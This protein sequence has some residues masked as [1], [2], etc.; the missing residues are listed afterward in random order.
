MRNKYRSK[1]ITRDGLTFD[2]LKEYR[3]F[4]ELL[5]LEKSGAITDLKRQVAFELVPA[6]FEYIKTDEVYKRGER[7]GLPKFKRVCVE[8]SVVYNADFTYTEK[9]QIV[10]EDTKGFRTKDY[11]IKRKLML[12]FHDI[13][14][15]EI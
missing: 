13:K 8:Q 5:L 10:V 11:I 14:I 7:K 9:G 6:Q 12:F 15:K 4:R 2:S 3:R 1:K